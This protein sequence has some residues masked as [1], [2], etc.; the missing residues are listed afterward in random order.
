MIACGNCARP[1]DAGSRFCA[2][3]GAPLA[4]ATF[5]AEERRVVTVVFADVVGYTTLAERL[6]PERVKRL[7][8]SCF[9]R[10]VVDIEAF[11]GR[12][13]K[14][15]GDAILALFGAPV[16][17]EDDADR[18][19][20]AALR[21]QETL[22]AFVAEHADDHP[23]RHL[24][25]RIGINTGEVLVGTLA[26][27]DYTAMGDVVNT[28]SRLQA[29]APPGG[30][31]IGDATASL[32]R[33]SVTVEPF[34]ATPIRGREQAEVAWL[35][36]SA[37]ATSARPVRSDIAFIGRV[38]ERALLE[39]AIGLVRRGRSGLVSIVGEPG[40]GKSR[41]A[42]EIVTALRPEAIVIEAPC[43]P[44]G[45]SN[46]WA[47][48]RHGVRS[49]LSLPPDPSTAE[50]REAVERRSA[51]LWSLAPGDGPLTDLI[52]VVNYV[53]GNPSAL[54][55]LDAATARDRV[56]GVVTDMMR[57]HAQTRLT[58]LWL[59]NLQWADPLVR[60]L[61]AVL[62]RS[63]SDLPFLLLTTQ[64]ADD[65][66]T[67][68]PAQLDRSLVLRVPLAPLTTA[69]SA[70]IVRA[71]V[72]RESGTRTLDDERI[73]ELLA[74]GGGNPLFLI[75]MTVLATS[76]GPTADLPGSL[77]ALIA[78][79]LDRLPAS[80]RAIIDNAAV[81][82]ESGPT[83]ALREFAEAMKQAYDEHDLAE[84]VADG[85]VDVTDGW[86]RF[87]SAVVREVAY[88]TLTKRTRAQR[89]AGVALAMSTEK[90]HLADAVA[91]HAGTAAELVAE[92]GPIDGVPRSIGALAIRSLVRAAREA[93]ESGRSVQA[94]QQAGRAL[95]LCVAEPADERQLLLIRASAHLDLRRFAMAGADARRALELAR[96]A[97]DIV[98]EAEARRRLGTA[99]H[100]LGDL[101]TARGE[102]DAALEL[103]RGIEDPARLADATRA[104]GFAELFGG[105][106]DAARIH[107]ESALSMYQTLGDERGDAWAR[108][109][110]AW[111]SF[112][113]GDATQ[114]DHLLGQARA[115]FGR[116]GDRVGI[117][118]AEGLRA[119]VLYF[120]RRSAEAEALAESVIA[121]AT[122]WGDT[123]ALWMMNTLLANMRLWDG[124]IVE[125][126]HLAEKALDGFRES[127]DRYGL[128]NAL[129]PL[130]RARAALGKFAEAKRGA[131][132]SMSLGNSFG[133]LGLAVQSAAAVA[134]HLGDGHEALVLVEQVIERNRTMGASNSEAAVIRSIALCQLGR[135]DEALATIDGVAVDDGFPY[136][137]AARALVRALS[138]D[139]VGAV[140][141]ADAV[142]QTPGASYFDIAL[143]RVGAAVA[144]AAHG[145]DAVAAQ[146]DQRIAALASIARSSGDVV[147]AGIARQLATRSSRGREPG[148]GTPQAERVDVIGPGLGAGWTRIVD[149]GTV[150]A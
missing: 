118:W 64:R 46:V 44:Y 132:E 15:L 58:V 70:T 14:V 60:D 123:W 112:L 63:L 24:L 35:V 89:H 92:L 72:E 150:V 37:T 18:A 13:D 65:E 73:D 40:S 84:L 140:E 120:Q 49:L 43:A 146:R 3:C 71:V 97:G 29:L 77:R 6:D 28:A 48:L 98:D 126:E 82:G 59:D 11:G 45:E 53:V 62:V 66:L 76:C 69:D 12:V 23:A 74:R 90:E 100:M 128:M 52:E 142:E 149:A 96:S 116:L 85:L 17:H 25:M 67:W 83:G 75:E 41:L 81:I 134:M 105:S 27:T 8:E 137:L 121:D 7:I 4:A 145:D 138:A 131:E 144:A 130:N 78:A 113:S 148:D 42:G 103:F 19:V 10:L 108:H 143:A 21:M 111:A 34:G 124:R 147:F 127:G 61:A 135:V 39:S 20:R 125:A 38:E 141:D 115:Q 79:R 91:H 68:P 55:R 2:N 114:A 122:S 5:A 117:N 16:A 94:V 1:V 93:A 26:G 80:R 102:L 9:A 129:A 47:P 87:H 32:C 31:L 36:S 110:I 33:T 57:R 119:Y 30:V 56:T 139:L 104:R 51:E 136:G 99:A 109:N 106:L 22:A 88:Q 95:D 86:W 101:V 50:I 133:E 107:L 54:D